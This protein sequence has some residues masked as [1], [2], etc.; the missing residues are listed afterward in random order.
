MRVA[1]SINNNDFDD[2]S[3]YIYTG[4]PLECIDLNKISDQFS[5]IRKIYSSPNNATEL[6]SAIRYGKRYILKGIS[7]DFRNDPIQNLALSKEFEIGLSLDHPNI[8]Q[9]IGY[10]KINGLGQVII[11][12]FFDG[13]PLNE[14][15][16]SV[17]ITHQ[18]ARSI[19]IQVASAIKYIHSKGIL[20][21][22]LKPS[23]ILVS[24]NGLLVK[25][26]DFNLSDSESFITLK[27]P[28]GTK[29]Y[30]APELI[31][32]TGQPSTA[33]DI[34]SFGI[35]LKELAAAAKDPDIMKIADRCTD[36][37]PQKRPHLLDEIS[38]PKPDQPVTKSFSHI[39]SSKIM[40]Y[41]LSIICLSFI[42][43]IYYFINS[44]KLL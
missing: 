27:N 37:D 36:V 44:K 17:N 4:N 2:T 43:L 31:N 18:T 25:I 30:I 20:H 40:T 19:A 33:S 39:L 41:V 32:R 14:Y 1:D 28:A 23:N 42:V 3:D 11:L 24:H 15:L 21:K 8:R 29:N 7:E 22:D 38:F 9:T 10:E 6:H 35:I 26:I 16:R 5:N 12:E 13:K 34:Y